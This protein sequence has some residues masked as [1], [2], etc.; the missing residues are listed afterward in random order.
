MSSQRLITPWNGYLRITAHLFGCSGFISL[1]FLQHSA[2][3]C[4]VKSSSFVGYAIQGYLLLTYLFFSRYG[5]CFSWTLHS[6]CWILSL[7]L[8]FFQL[9]LPVEIS[10]FFMKLILFVALTATNKQ[11]CRR[12]SQNNKFS[13]MPLELQTLVPYQYIDRLIGI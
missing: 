6:V 1:L 9:R 2:Q 10:V 4:F 5:L 13:S 12:C 8:V 3:L 11:S 7:L